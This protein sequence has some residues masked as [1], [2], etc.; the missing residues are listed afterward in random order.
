MR[1]RL[2]VNYNIVLIAIF[3]RVQLVLASAIVF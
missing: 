3:I 1:L 2:L